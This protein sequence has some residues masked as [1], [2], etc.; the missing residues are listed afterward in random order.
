[1][2][3]FK[4]SFANVLAVLLSFF[5]IAS[6]SDGA[7]ADI[8][9]SPIPS[10][11]NYESVIDDTDG[12]LEP[13]YELSK[14]FIDATV[15]VNFNVGLWGD[16]WEWSNFAEQYV[17]LLTYVVIM[18][19]I[20]LLM[21]VIGIIF[22]ASR[23]CCNCCGAK[24]VER[25]PN[26]GNG[27]LIIAGGFTVI[28]S[29]FLIFAIAVG[30]RSN[31]VIEKGSENIFDKVVT[32]L[33]DA[34]KY[35]DNTFRQMEHL[36]T[37]NYNEFSTG[38]STQLAEI[39]TTLEAEIKTDDLDTVKVGITKLQDSISNLEATDVAAQ[40]IVNNKPNMDSAKIETNNIAQACKS[41]LNPDIKKK[42]EDMETEVMAWNIPDPFDFDELTNK[43]NEMKGIDWN[44]PGI[45]LD[46]MK[47]FGPGLKNALI[48]L[49][50]DAE[51]KTTEA[52]DEIEK[53]LK[54]YKPQM[55]EV[56]EWM[57]DRIADIN[58][59]RGYYNDYGKLRFGL[60]FLL[61]LLL[62]F[63]VIF[64]IL[65]FLVGMF[66][67]NPYYKEKGCG[68]T[69][70][71]SDFFMI[72]ASF[73]FIFT[74]VFAI[75]IVGYYAFGLLG[76]R[77]I[78]NTF[79]TMD[80]VE[81][82]KYLDNNLEISQYFGDGVTLEH[83]L[84]TCRDNKPAYEVL[85]LGS[86]FN[87]DDIIDYL[88]DFKIDEA[89]QELDKEITKLIVAFTTN[90]NFDPTVILK[91][92]INLGL[93][94][95]DPPMHEDQR[96]IMQTLL[97]LL[98]EIKGLD[99]SIPNIDDAIKIYEDNK[100][101]EN[102][103]PLKENYNTFQ[104]E[105]KMGGTTSH[106][107]TLTEFDGYI[108]AYVDSVKSPAFKELGKQLTDASVQ[109]VEIYLNR[110]KDQMMT[111]V[112]LCLPVDNAIQATLNEAC[113]NVFNPINA[114]WVANFFALMAFIP[115]VILFIY[116]NGYFRQYTVTDD[117]RYR[118]QNY[119]LYNPPGTRGSTVQAY[120]VR[121]HHQ[122]DPN[123][124]P[125]QPYPSQ[126]ARKPAASFPQSTPL[127]QIPSNHYYNPNSGSIGTVPQSPLY[128]SL[129][130]S[131]NTLSSAAALVEKSVG[132]A[133]NP[134]AKA[135]QENSLRRQQ[136]YPFAMKGSSMSSEAQR[137][138]KDQY[139]RF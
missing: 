20:G 125:F 49:S 110:I 28:F 124:T 62:I 39:G 66:C 42:C 15:P 102:F 132:F 104:A 70:V 91:D 41:H 85:N 77:Y 108:A 82:L 115:L 37:N 53:D 21:P 138:G 73:I 89:L 86:I 44:K 129:N 133:K 11:T 98:K 45:T 29:A 97:T 24:A 5:I 68:N 106:D 93:Q 83:L 35:S 105:I 43:K 26:Q 87:L 55:E 19:V 27:S 126:S 78:C 96:V 113:G 76:Q 136:D 135:A 65:G 127:P 90:N 72:N 67:R 118:E 50:E 36:M 52:G 59:A 51:K 71:S 92:I 54:S 79:H 99:A 121:E 122:P 75:A 57:N 95:F 47:S 84:N 109:T 103:E 111:T 1:M 58:E 112:G 48:V 23:C 4:F 80:N 38:F 56:K 134:S 101:I 14:D 107:V 123:T 139:T 10:F 100:L 18:V 88:E 81:G 6:I 94:S 9:Y 25:H 31:V 114:F 63:M 119:Y 2:L 74:I 60:T 32:T 22:C 69:S 12:T 40:L 64:I 128:P 131:D 7:K 8:D 130:S 33:S 17:G 34:I 137:N 116:L 16:D 61:P 120:D 3:V 46:G 117:D 30:M 13:I